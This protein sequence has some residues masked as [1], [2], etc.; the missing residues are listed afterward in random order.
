MKFKETFIW[1]SWIWYSYHCCCCTENLIIYLNI[2]FILLYH[3]NIIPQHHSIMVQIDIQSILVVML[4]SHLFFSLS[5]DIP[6]Q[7]YYSSLVKLI[8]FVINI[9]QLMSLIYHV[10]SQFLWNPIHLITIWITKIICLLW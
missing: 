5:I 8:I 7:I 10:L 3:Q 6:T 1:S 4:L 9:L 2:S